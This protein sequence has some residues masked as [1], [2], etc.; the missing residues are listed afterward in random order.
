M[1]EEIYITRVYF[2]KI[3][4]KTIF[5]LQHIIMILKRKYLIKFITTGCM[6]WCILILWSFIDWL[7]CELWSWN[8][9]D[10]C[11]WLL[12]SNDWPHAMW[13]LKPSKFKAQWKLILPHPSPFSTSTNLPFTFFAPPRICLLN[14]MME[15]SQV[16][17]GV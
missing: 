1:I 14:K 5:F 12:A 8:W 17:L 15:S 4:I 16:F 6:P 11:D 2:K 3:L 7:G 13:A 10:L 9:M